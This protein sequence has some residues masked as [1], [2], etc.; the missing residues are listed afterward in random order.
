MSTR[1]TATFEITGWDETIYAE[2][3]EGPKLSRATVRKI[4]QGDI[5]GESTAELLMSRAKDGSAGYVALERVV[6][7]IGDRSGSFDVQ[8]CATQGGPNPRAIWLVVPGSGTGELRGL[9][10]QA[11]YQHDEN[12]ATFT[13]DYDF[14]AEA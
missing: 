3:T 14:E 12:G 9:S 1:A 10:G 6:G 7:R 11:T 8:H 4:F 2:P 5:A 13:L